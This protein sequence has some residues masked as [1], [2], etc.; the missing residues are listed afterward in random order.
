MA[1]PDIGRGNVEN[2]SNIRYRVLRHVVEDA[3]DTGAPQPD[4]DD[5]N[6][7]FFA[8]GRDLES[9]YVN[10]KY[11]E[12][13]RE[14]LARY[15]S[16]DYL[17]PHSKV[18]RD[19][20]TKQPAR[21]DW[22][23]W[24]MMGLIG[25][26]VGFVGFLLHQLIDLLAELKHEK[27]RELIEA[28][29]F[30]RAW[31]WVTAVSVGLVV[32]SSGTVVFIRPS[33]GG[34]G[35]P[36]IIAFLNGTLVRH[37]F[38]I[39]TLIVKFV[40]CVC[41]VS[42]GMPVGPEGPMIHLGALI[43][44]GL[45]QFRSGTF[46]FR[47]PFFSRF[48][49]SEDRRNFVS[50]GAAAGIA[51]AFGAPVGGLLF[52][53][54]EVSS[55]W[56]MKLSWQTF[57]CCMVSTFTTDLF[58][59][60]FEAFRYMGDF[61]LFKTEKYILFQV[62]KEIALNFIAVIPTVVVGAA[63]GILGAVFTFTNLKIARA[64]RRLLAKMNSPYRQLVQL[65]E[66]VLIMV[67][68]GTLTVFLPTMASC[69]TFTCHWEGNGNPFCNPK[70]PIYTEKTVEHFNCPKGAEITINGTLYRN[71]TFNPVATLLSVTGEK[72]VKHLFSRQTHLEFD[73]IPLIMV[74]PCYFLLAC[75]ASGTAISSGVVV[76][77]LFIG[78]MI[79][80]IVGRG[81]VALF[82]VNTTKYWL[83]MDPGAF[84]L[85]GAAAFFGG[86]SRLTMSLTVIM[87]ELT[88]D[89]QFLL[90]IMVAIMVAKWVGDFVTHPFYHSLLEF[91]C[92]PFL[93]SE[94][95]I[96]YEGKKNLNLELYTTKYAMTSPVVTLQ[97]VEK[98]SH[99]AKLLLTTKHG[100]FPLVCNKGS[101]FEKTF[102]G[103]LTRQVYCNNAS[104]MKILLMWQ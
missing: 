6:H 60:A 8:R 35:I 40:S 30:L 54:E 36:E 53:M 71:G 64:R 21:L 75:W 95:V 56:N 82:G 79:G 89:I 28:R 7:S 17:P 31:L 5:D 94:P 76:P 102:C 43:G 66:P 62:D 42:S 63:G 20:I 13:E 61:G 46:G 93:D 73:F 51:S 100:G 23:R 68:M 65:C 3:G 80:R 49:N 24:V 83:W 19:W 69:A 4:D 39:K 27:A 9:A 38:N 58:N 101:G 45:S 92:I 84:A 22:D 15:E 70:P 1:E 12:K 26:A 104:S 55:F 86:V 11:T 88:N 103:L 25:F 32:I 10:H 52:S 87:M 14:I 81:L 67:I 33:A 98:V 18:Y 57:F 41:A 96:Y 74:L 50:A 16:L 47:L 85:L 2:E 78:G 97:K 99:L 44:A 29:D 48:R 90:L 72:A 77:K 59:S 34:S 91:K 37:I